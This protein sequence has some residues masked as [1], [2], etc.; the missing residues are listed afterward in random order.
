MGTPIPGSD[1]GLGTEKNAQKIFNYFL[2]VGEF[3]HPDMGQLDLLWPLRMGSRNPD[4][5]AQAI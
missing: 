1:T 4:A 2:D 5:M 3:N